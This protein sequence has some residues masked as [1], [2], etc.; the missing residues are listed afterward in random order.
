MDVRGDLTVT[1]VRH[2]NTFGPDEIP[3]RIGARTDLPL[4]ASGIVQARA[5]GDA[6]AHRRFDRAIAAPLRRTRA[7]IDHILAR[8]ST[9]PATETADWL[10]EIDH[11]PDE[12]ATDA[13]VIDRIGAA[14][15][16]AWDARAVPPPDW[17]VE[18]D[19]R[20]AGWRGLWR[21]GQGDVLIVTSNGAARFALF[22]DPDVQAQA[23]GLSTLKLRTG[24]YGVI[25]RRAGRLRLAAW[26]LRP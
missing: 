4:V 22:S 11:G 14:A 15:L 6:F 16:A 2:G 3:R 1:I 12:D 17:I 25:E 24:A 13:A 18:P 8:Q 19:R 26:D 7:T 9:P 5:L 23:T 21:A 10:T 20:V